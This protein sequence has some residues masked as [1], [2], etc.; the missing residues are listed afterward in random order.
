MNLLLL[1]SSDPSTQL[2]SALL[3]EVSTRHALLLFFL[4]V[5]GFGLDDDGEVVGRTYRPSIARIFDARHGEHDLANASLGQVVGSLFAKSSREES[6]V[7]LEF[8]LV[9]L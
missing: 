2:C 6:E 7:H 9:N 5:E 8:G 1:L 4:L 3:S